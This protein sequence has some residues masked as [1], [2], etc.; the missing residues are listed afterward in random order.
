MKKYCDVCGI[1][2]NKHN[3]AKIKIGRLIKFKN[4]TMIVY[5]DTCKRCE[6]LKIK[7]GN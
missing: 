7:R 1:E 2:L 4:G 3:I 6:K 5:I